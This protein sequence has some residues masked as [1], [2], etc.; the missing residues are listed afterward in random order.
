MKMQIL[1]Q[2]VW[3][4]RNLKVLTSYEAVPVLP[5]QGL[6]VARASIAFRFR[7]NWIPISAQLLSSCGKLGTSLNLCELQF[8]IM[9]ANWQVLVLPVDFEVSGRQVLGH[10]GYS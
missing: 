9:V 7:H 4:P 3:E 1:I 2:Q 8:L 5:V 10:L 6:Q